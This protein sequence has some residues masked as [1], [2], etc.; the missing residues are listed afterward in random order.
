MVYVFG[1]LLFLTNNQ[2]SI[3]KNPMGLHFASDAEC[4]AYIADLDLPT[5]DGKV[6]GSQY[7]C[8]PEMRGQ[9]L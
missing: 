2:Y 5:S 9:S 6:I 7:V 3:S 1:L 8:I 4:R